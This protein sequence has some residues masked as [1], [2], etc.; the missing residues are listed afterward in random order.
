MRIS[1]S[2]I[3]DMMEAVEMRFGGARAPQAIEHGS[4]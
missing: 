2:D 3:R 4:A 1:R